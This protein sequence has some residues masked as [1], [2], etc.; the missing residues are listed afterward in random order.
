MAKSGLL[1]NRRKALAVRISH[2]LGLVALSLS[3]APGAFAA[4]SVIG[5]SESVKCF[6]TADAGIPDPRPCDR[7]LAEEDLLVRDRVATLVNRGIIYNLASKYD[8]AIADFEAA[9]AIDVSTAEAY[10]NRGNSRFYQGRLNDAVTDYSRAIDLKIDRLAIAHYD[11]AIAFAS[12][13]KFAEAKA[14][15]EAALAIDPDFQ[16]AS[17]KLASVNHILETPPRTAG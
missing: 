14:D 1:Y 4:M 7:A 2:I 15:L 11:R 13:G 10:L 12:L 16:L 5:T 6:E 8:R 3:I 17:E 9:L